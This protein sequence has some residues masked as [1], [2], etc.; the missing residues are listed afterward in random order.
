MR[1]TSHRPESRTPR[2]RLSPLTWLRAGMLLALCTLVAVALEEGGPRSAPAD[3]PVMMLP[4][5]YLAKD[6][7]DTPLA[8]GYRVVQPGSSLQDGDFIEFYFYWDSPSHGS[9]YSV[10]ADLS[11]LDAAAIDPVYGVYVGDTAIVVGEETTDTWAGFRFTWTLSDPGSIPDDGEIV[12]PVTAVDTVSSTSATDEALRFCLS[13]HPPEHV[14]TEFIG[15]PSRFVE[16]DGV[17]YYVVR[18][19]DR[20]EMESTWRYATGA[21]S[22]TADF[23]GADNTFDSADLFAWP[24]DG[25]GDTLVTW[26]LEYLLSEDGFTGSD[27]PVP[28]RIY[29]GDGGCGRDSVIVTIEVDNDGPEGSPVFESEIPE[30]T[31]EAEII[32]YGTAPEGSSELLLMRNST[33]EHVF[34]LFGVEGALQFYDTLAL[35]VGANHIV[36]Y[37]RDVAGNLSAPSAEYVIRRAGAP[38]FKRAVVNWPNPD[39]VTADSTASQPEFLVRNGDFI[40]FYCYWDSH[41]NYEVFADFTQIDSQAP[42]VVWGVPCESIDSVMVEGEYETWFCYGFEYT[43]SDGNLLTDDN[44][45]PIPITAINPSTGDSTTTRNLRFCL[46]NQPPEHLWTRIVSPGEFNV[47]NGDTLYLVS[48]GGNLV[49]QSCWLTTSNLWISADLS[50][51]DVSYETNRLTK[52]K[53]DSLSTDST[54]VYQLAYNFG[55]NACCEAGQDPYPLVGRVFVKDNG[56]G[57]DTTPPLYFEMDNEGPEGGPQLTGPTPHQ[58]AEAQLTVSGTVPEGATGVTASILTETLE[59]PVIVSAEADQDLNFTLVLPLEEGQNVVTMVA[60]D[61]LG[62]PSTETLEL[63]IFRVATLLINLPK[64]F[65]PGD[66]IILAGPEGWESID[67]QIYNLEGSQ[68]RS[69]SYQ[70]NP[71][72]YHVNQTWDGRNADGIDVRRG[73]YLLRIRTVSAAS[74]SEKEE[75][76]AF[77]FKR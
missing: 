46:S 4:G 71:I 13:N 33:S 38:E 77:V 11:A 30:D 47:R 41:A 34:R 40:Q 23:T 74:R 8:K 49:I 18:N 51:V 35:G 55:V 70:G 66:E 6:A 32:L 43:I 54:R 62:N 59:D 76:R 31:E 63:V 25:V 26:R 73:A 56:C 58:T 9:P 61:A 65:A 28:L 72:L 3:S 39:E 64:P 44:D 15:D 57:R 60:T 14:E 67:L 29:A 16:H 21:L 42:G 53:I 10:T 22:V 68:I 17:T 19:G 50:D 48:N 45:I 36:A 24:V 52:S 75:V 12:V 1:L 5:A 37:G 27:Y 69:W 2:L 20:L 7:A